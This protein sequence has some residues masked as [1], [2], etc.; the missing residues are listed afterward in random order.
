MGSKTDVLQAPPSRGTGVG[1]GHPPSSAGTGGAGSSSTAG[2]DDYAQKMRLK[3]QN[4]RIALSKQGARFELP[5]D[6]KSLE[7]Q[8]PADYLRRCCHVTKRRENLYKKHFNNHD[9]DKDSK[10]TLKEVDKAM[11]DVFV[12]TID[13][14]TIE[15]VT[16]LVGLVIPKQT[17]SSSVNNQPIAPQPPSSREQQQKSTT[18]G[19]TGSAPSNPSTAPAPQ[20]EA[21][22][23][24][25]LVPFTLFSPLCALSERLMHH[26]YSTG[27][28]SL[29]P[30][31]SQ[32][33]KL[34]EAD[35]SSLA[36]KLHGLN[37][38]SQLSTLLYVILD[39]LEYLP[40]TKSAV[41]EADQFDKD[42]LPEEAAGQMGG[43][44][45]EGAAAAAAGPPPPRSSEAS[46]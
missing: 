42:I 6:M 40:K 14:E 7:N 20:A 45:V 12:D 4:T 18:G 32:K 34:E 26:K 31:Y 28:A 22:V 37:I 38:S 24:P 43:V 5:I 25:S 21:P 29:D 13:S 15:T 2:S 27:E 33:D 23:P 35:F 10:L 44:E 1:A 39:P 11:R 36:W 9:K 30:N 8:G 3:V 46:K 19:E 16:S 41:E 17:N